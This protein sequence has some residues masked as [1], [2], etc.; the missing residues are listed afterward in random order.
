MIIRDDWNKHAIYVLRTC[1]WLC[2]YMYGVVPICIVIQY[3][4]IN[5]I[6]I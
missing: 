5:E 6:P 3:V 2:V 1:A 4:L